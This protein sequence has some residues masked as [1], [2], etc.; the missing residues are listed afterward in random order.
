MTI[1]A[2]D[3]HGV[4]FE[5]SQVEHQR[6]VALFK[7]S[8]AMHEP[9]GSNAAVYAAKTDEVLMDAQRELREATGDYP[10]SLTELFDFAVLHELFGDREDTHIMCNFLKVF[11][12]LMQRETHILK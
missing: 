1:A 11:Y 12:A 7:L 2:T 4:K 8:E 9:L 5:I 3:I 10:E 6:L